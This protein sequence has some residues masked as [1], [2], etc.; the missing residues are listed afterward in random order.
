MLPEA[1]VYEAKKWIGDGRQFIY[2]HALNRKL[3]PEEHCHDF[4]EIIYLFSGFGEHRVN[5][6]MQRMQAGD[7][8]FLRP[9]DAH[10]F[11]EQSDQ[12]ELFSISA[13]AMN[14]SDTMNVPMRNLPQSP[15]GTAK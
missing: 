2:S 9:G 11:V 12:L 5:G 4:F 14:S 15:S 8:C 7:V 1:K 6:S 13:M 10:L 3:N